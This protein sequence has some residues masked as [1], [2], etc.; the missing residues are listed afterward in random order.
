M[1]DA[2]VDESNEIKDQN[3]KVKQVK[4]QPTEKKDYAFISEPIWPKDM[5]Y[6][7]PVN[8]MEEESK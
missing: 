7:K 5:K 3:L 4:S 2:W 6:V 8:L 1:P